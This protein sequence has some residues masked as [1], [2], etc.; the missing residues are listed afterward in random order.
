MGNWRV[1]TTEIAHT[2]FM[3]SLKCP[4]LAPICPPP[5][6]T[7]CPKADALFPIVS[8]ASIVAKVIRDRSLTVCQKVCC[9]SRGPQLKDS[10]EG[11]LYIANQAVAA[12]LPS[13]ALV[14]AYEPVPPPRRLPYPVNLLAATPDRLHG[15]Y[16]PVVSF[17]GN[18]TP[19]TNS[20]PPL[21]CRT[22]PLQ[23]GAG[24]CRGDGQRVPG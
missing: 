15:L 19:S 17:L 4:A 2:A 1:D 21:A 12:L 7:V 9:G 6:C 5:F 22:I 11:V 18:N 10:S 8:A 16:L 13:A 20:P 24:P 14:R 23:S 3:C